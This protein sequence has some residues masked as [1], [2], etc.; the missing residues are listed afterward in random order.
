MSPPKKRKNPDPDDDSS[1]DSDVP[2]RP[3]RSCRLEAN[4]LAELDS[5]SDTDQRQKTPTRKRRREENDEV[6]DNEEI[7]EE[8]EEDDVHMME[9]PQKSRRSLT[10]VY[11]G[12]RM[13][14]RYSDE[15]RAHFAAYVQ[16]HP[17]ESVNKAILTTKHKYIMF[18][19]SGSGNSE[20][21]KRN[22]KAIQTWINTW[23]KK[24][25]DDMVVNITTDPNHPGYDYDDDAEEPPFIDDYKAR[26][27]EVI[28]DLE[29][30]SQECEKYKVELENTNEACENYK[31]LYEI[32]SQKL[33]SLQLSSRED[34]LSICDLKLKL[35]G[36]EHQSFQPVVDVEKL[37]SKELD[38]EN[39]YTNESTEVENLNEEPLVL[40]EFPHEETPALPEL[41]NYDNDT[42]Y[43]VDLMRALETGASSS[44]RTPPRQKSIKKNPFYE[45]LDDD[46]F[47]SSETSNDAYEESEN[48]SFV[49][50]DPPIFSNVTISREKPNS[51]R[52]T[53]DINENLSTSDLELEQNNNEDYRISE[54]DRNEKNKTSSDSDLLAEM[55][56]SSDE[57]NENKVDQSNSRSDTSENEKDDN[58][59]SP[60]VT[61]DLSKSDDSLELRLSISNSESSNDETVGSKPSPISSPEVSES[62]YSYEVHLSASLEDLETFIVSSP[63]EST[64]EEDKANNNNISLKKLTVNI[65]KLPKKDVTKP[66]IELVRGN[67]IVARPRAS[68]TPP[69]RT[70]KKKKII[71]YRAKKGQSARKQKEIAERQ[72]KEE[73]NKIIEEENRKKKEDLDFLNDGKKLKK[74]FKISKSNIKES[75][76]TPTTS[77][78][79]GSSRLEHSE[80]SSSLVATMQPSQLVSSS[81]EITEDLHST[82]TGE[83]C[84]LCRRPKP[85]KCDPESS[86]E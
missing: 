82:P 71:R 65:E 19:L 28:A 67:R 69:P 58:E 45:F 39:C 13:K 2:Q 50:E 49:D 23:R 32:V 85:C 70:Q 3:F 20:Q 34:K 18:V 84:Y 21:I 6:F 83:S 55:K 37:D 14:P 38:N 54:A 25:L 42:D 76:S 35:Y 62:D 73:R 52:V 75:S 31:L 60:K 77:A 24:L 59:L 68:S 86:S 47:T 10:T 66:F 63:N 74:T 64:L 22:R 4:S 44:A 8:Y 51:A 26:L 40:P 43:V 15:E 78:E 41:E 27:T 56:I 46:D 29:D 36:S 12:A 16:E 7:D 57:S 61:S 9:P 48:D 79:T 80:N 30:M 1:Q 81:S 5:S 72:K 53:E 11:A 17:N 33:K